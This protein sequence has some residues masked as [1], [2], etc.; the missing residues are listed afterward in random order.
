MCIGAVVS[1]K[2]NYD[3]N[4]NSHEKHEEGWQKF[5]DASAQTTTNNNDNQRTTE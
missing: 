2:N 4:F 3:V 1:D 5:H